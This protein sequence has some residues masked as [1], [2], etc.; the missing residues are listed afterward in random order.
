MELDAARNPDHDLTSDELWA[1]VL[2]DL[3]SDVYHS[4]AE[5]PPCETFSWY[6]FNYGPGPRPLRTKQHPWGFPC[7][8]GKL[9]GKIETANLLVRR[10]IEAP[11]VAYDHGVSYMLDFLRT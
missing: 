11:N 1:S 5:S 3:V 10:S 2:E 8:Q 9:K 6:L 7:L 4:L